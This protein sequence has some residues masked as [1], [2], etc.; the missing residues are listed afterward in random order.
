M[1]AWLLQGNPF[2]CFFFPTRPIHLAV[3]NNQPTSLHHLLDVMTSLPN[4]RHCI[5]SY[6]Y[7]RQVGLK[8]LVIKVKEGSPLATG[9]E[10]LALCTPTELKSPQ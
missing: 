8:S 7:M 2:E 10:V 3:I 5:N 1:Y 9:V 4:A 6:N